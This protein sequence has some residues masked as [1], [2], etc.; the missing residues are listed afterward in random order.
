MT[1]RR[2]WLLVLAL[3]GPGLLC[4]CRDSN[5]L[6]RKAI[7]G[8]VTLDGAPLKQGSINFQPMQHGGVSS[9]AVIADGKFAIAAEKGLPKGK[10]RV[11]INA[12]EA[13]SGG[14]AAEMPG[15]IAPA[16]KELVPAN[17]NVQSELTA[18]VGDEK[19]C[20]F[21]YDLKSK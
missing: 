17:Y 19:T 15:D 20:E 2:L 7:S 4:G 11:V 13:G 9:G 16:P 12:A 6:G 21:K 14:A 1:C 5:P 10:Y 18:Q 3:I 8:T